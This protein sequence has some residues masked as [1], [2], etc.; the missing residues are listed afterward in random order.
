MKLLSRADEL[1]MLAV[2][3][4]KDNAYCIE[5]LEQ[6]ENNSGKEWTLGGVYAV[7]NR[8]EQNGLVSSHLGPPSAE[9]GGKRKRFYKV[10]ETGLESLKEIKKVEKS[11]WDGLSD[12]ILEK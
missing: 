7:L 1:I 6:A 2:W 8:L 5:I 4:L 3:R 10:T 11:M 9:R 12:I